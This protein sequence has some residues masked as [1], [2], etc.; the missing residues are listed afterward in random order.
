MLYFLKNEFFIA[1]TLAALSL[2]SWEPPGEPACAEVLLLQRGSREDAMGVVVVECRCFLC[3]PTSRN[4][5]ERPDAPRA[6][7]TNF[8]MPEVSVH[9]AAP[10]SSKLRDDEDAAFCSFVD[11]PLKAL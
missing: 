11:S 7:R 1:E 2:R 3:I 10:T 5:L 6:G 8:A 9:C 4:E